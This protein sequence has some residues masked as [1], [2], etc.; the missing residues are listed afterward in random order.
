MLF[1]SHEL[2]P[3]RVKGPQR[4]R[5]TPDWELEKGGIIIQGGSYVGIW[6]QDAVNLLPG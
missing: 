5:D 4:A 6:L 1:K 2:D 3:H